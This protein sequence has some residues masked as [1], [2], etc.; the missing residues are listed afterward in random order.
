MLPEIYEFH[1]KYIFLA[2]CKQIQMNL[3]TSHSN[4]VGTNPTSAADPANPMNIGAPTLLA[5]IDPAI[6]K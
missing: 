4:M 1:W 5:N 3:Q 6:Y 2:T